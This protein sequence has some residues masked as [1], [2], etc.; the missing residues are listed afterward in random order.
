MTVPPKLDLILRFKRAGSINIASEEGFLTVSFLSF[1]VLT[2]LLS[3]C[4]GRRSFARGRTVPRRYRTIGVESRV[5]FR[6]YYRDSI[7][8]KNPSLDTEAISCVSRLC[9][10]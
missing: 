9:D 6:M 1:V 2:I 4:V 10:L 8:L 5:G 7:V 3:I